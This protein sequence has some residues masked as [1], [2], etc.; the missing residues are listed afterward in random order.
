MKRNSIRA[1]VLLSLLMLFTK[2]PGS[3]VR[4]PKS[5]SILDSFC[6]VFPVGTKQPWNQNKKLISF[7]LF[8]QESAK[9]E[10]YND[11][12]RWFLQGAM[13][14][15][16]SARLYYPDW[17]VRIYTF[18]LSADIETILL[19]SGDNVELVRCHMDSS[20][21]T[22]SSRKM[23]ARF[24]AYDDPSVAIFIS[25]D[26]DSRF[27]PKELFAVNEW[28]SSNA[29]FHSMRD[30]EFHD[31]PVLGGMFGMKRGA[32]ANQVTMSQ[33]L[34]DALN[35]NQR[36]LT[37][38]RGEDQ[39]FLQTHVWPLVRNNCIDHDI[40]LDRCRR[41][42]AAY[43]KD[44]PMSLSAGAPQIHVG[45]AFKPF[46]DRPGSNVSGYTCSFSCDRKNY[47]V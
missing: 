10:N 38:A 18:Q 21:N 12:F 8:K 7:A 15:V 29:T 35:Q 2:L 28:I 17:I 39:S 30:H 25:R 27:S 41:Y 11:E 13:H 46:D 36:E 42:G 1:F 34:N 43:C 31:A 24:L 45:E 20:L 37:G 47:R 26:L 23:I 14:N 5:S 40:R 22:S 19:Q 9:H 4:A 44:Y 16:K 33:T 32:L 3:K 6:E